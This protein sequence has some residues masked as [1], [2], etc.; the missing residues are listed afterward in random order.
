MAV[1]ALLRRWN[2]IDD[3]G[4]AAVVSEPPRGESTLA[5]GEAVGLAGAAFAAGVAAAVLTRSAFLAAAWRSFC[6]FRLAAMALE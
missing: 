4:E 1:L 6:S 5:S 3:L 2:V